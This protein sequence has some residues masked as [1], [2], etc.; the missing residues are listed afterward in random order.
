M[1]KN[2]P[3]CDENY[4]T[5]IL[6]ALLYAN[7]TP[8][9]EFLRHQQSFTFSKLT[10]SYPYLLLDVPNDNVGSKKS[11][12]TLKMTIGSKKSISTL[13]LNMQLQALTI[14]PFLPH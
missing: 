9:T 7:K 11:M 4:N 8:K 6:V 2:S 14:T 3:S 5:T 13:K 10:P 1:T 12:S